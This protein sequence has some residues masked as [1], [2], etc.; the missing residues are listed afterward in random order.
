MEMKLKV[1][2]GIQRTFVKIKESV[3]ATVP[4]CVTVTFRPLGRLTYVWDTGVKEVKYD[5]EFTT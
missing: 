3:N 1:N 5:V 2:D 4:I